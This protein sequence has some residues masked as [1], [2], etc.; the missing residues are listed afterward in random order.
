MKTF[1]IITLIFLSCLKGF[2]QN[3]NSFNNKVEYEM[4]LSFSSPV[5]YKANFYYNNTNSLFEYKEFSEKNETLVNE[6]DPE[7]NITINL[8]ENN[9]QYISTNKEKNELTQLVEGLKKNE[10]YELKEP[11]PVI[12][13]TILEEVKKI[14]QHNCNKAI[15]TFRGRNYTVWFTTDIQTNFGPLKLNGL[16]G[17]ILEL[18][19]ETKEV[20]LNALVI[21]QE[22]RLSEDKESGLKTISR[23]DYNVMLSKMM[24]DIEESVKAVTSRMDR[25]FKAS[26]KISKPKAIEMDYDLAETEK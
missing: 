3:D 25:G 1:L 24:K 7:L 19:D 17:L 9:M 22:I 16:P 5:F 8:S 12:A 10:S 26:Y 6:K 20:T 21:K 4:I 2:C 14:N 13:W 11:I 18:S 23:F 15:C